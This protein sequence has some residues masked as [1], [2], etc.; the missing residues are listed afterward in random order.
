MSAF[1]LGYLLLA[2]SASILRFAIA[3]ALYHA[4]PIVLQSV[5]NRIGNS[6]DPRRS[7]AAAGILSAIAASAPPLTGLH[8]VSIYISV[9]CLAFLSTIFGKGADLLTNR[10]ARDRLQPAKPSPLL[11]MIHVVSGVL[12]PIVAGVLLA[13]V[14]PSTFVWFPVAL[15]LTS[16]ACAMLMR[17]E[18][19]PRAA[20]MPRGGQYSRAVTFFRTNP[21]A[22]RL[23]L[24]NVLA[25]LA[26]S[27]GILAYLPFV[28]AH[29]W[30]LSAE[31][32][33]FY[34]AFTALGAYVG[35]L[36]L[37]LRKRKAHWLTFVRRLLV[38]VG[39]SI[40]LC[41]PVIMLDGELSVPLAFFLICALQCLRSALTT[42]IG[43][44]I[45]RKLEHSAP[46]GVADSAI[47]LIELCSTA[48]VPA[49]LLIAG[50]VG[51]TA[52]GVML[53]M[54][55]GLLVIAFVYCTPCNIQPP[56]TDYDIQNT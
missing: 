13:A 4:I 21:W 31:S 9:A 44:A 42:M 22:F 23:G 11:A 43:S 6:R 26:L 14:T 49:G 34:S 17:I 27:V 55:A 20:Y 37:A 52:F 53:P 56:N 28:L 15:L 1:A 45:V 7:A 50:L 41:T 39:A 46:A 30:G 35:M 29:R 16:T 40:A 2:R 8:P 3:M 33:G 24:L 25:N 48:V 54:A 36:Y 10:I 32:L 12:G 38:M 51:L 18:P 19:L 47:G 5:A